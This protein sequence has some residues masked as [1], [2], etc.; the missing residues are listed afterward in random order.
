MTRVIAH[1]GAGSMAPENTIPAK[2]KLALRQVQI[3]G[4]LM[5]RAL[6]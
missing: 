5:S 4:R 1:R 3:S 6:K 2:A